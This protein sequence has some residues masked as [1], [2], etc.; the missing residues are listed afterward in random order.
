MFGKITLHVQC[1]PQTLVSILDKNVP[2]SKSFSMTPWHES[3]QAWD[4]VSERA[5]PFSLFWIGHFLWKRLKAWGHEGQDKGQ[6]RPWPPWC[7]VQGKKEEEMANTHRTLNSVVFICFFYDTTQLQF[8]VHAL[9]YAFAN[10]W[11]PNLC[12]YTQW[13]DMYL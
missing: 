10:W 5:R 13:T 3:Q 2:L 7:N 12:Y 6:Q 1:M 11:I 8:F 4:F 9:V